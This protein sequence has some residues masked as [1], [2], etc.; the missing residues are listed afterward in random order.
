MEW[1]IGLVLIVLCLWAVT[2][3]YLAGEDLARYDHG[4]VAP[5]GG[6]REPSTEHHE[7]VELLRELT[8]SVGTGLNRNRLQLMRAT[9]DDMGDSAD[10]T[11]IEITA[12]DVAGVP[13][14]WV[15]ADGADPDRR[16]LYLHGGAFSLGSPKSH[17]AI[18]TKFSRVAGASV[19]AV[20]YR[21][22][23]ENKRLDCLTDCQLA[24]RWIL[25]NGPNGPA[26]VETLF[27][28]GDSAGGNLTLAVIAWARDEGLRPADAAV[29]LSPATDST[30]TAPSLTTNIKTDH[31]LGPMFGRFAKMPRGLMLW[32]AWITNRVRPTDPR[33]SPLRGNLANLPPT[34]VHASEA[35]ILLDDAR[36]YVNKATEA[37][38]EATLE[39]W[40]HMLH[41]WHMFE[42]QLPEAQEAFNHIERFLEMNA[43]RQLAKT[44]SD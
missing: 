36:R 38:S 28:A 30:F 42:Q 39:T 5:V 37:G 17:R 19:L 14:E 8:G 2:R 21:L 18:T 26:P 9:M 23:P 29:A 10:L 1:I 7:V 20:D 31:M 41:V 40:H 13:G 6:E 35:E 22:V 27:V 34:L 11:G 33:V 4:A 15:R 25:D 24:Y 12:V 16:L 44:G 43:P 3:F 32:F